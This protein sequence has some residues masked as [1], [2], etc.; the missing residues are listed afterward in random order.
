MRRGI[1]VGIAVIVAAA[2]SVYGLTGAH[3]TASADTSSATT[4]TPQPVESVMHGAL[5]NGWE[6][7]VDE[8]GQS[9]ASQLHEML[10]RDTALMD[11]EAFA[12][13][14]PPA[15]DPKGEK[16]IQSD[17]N[18]LV[19][20]FPNQVKKIRELPQLVTG[21]DPSSVLP[22]YVADERTGTSDDVTDVVALIYR[23]YQSS[24]YNL[25]PANTKPSPMQ[26]LSRAEC[27]NL[28]GQ[29]NRILFGGEGN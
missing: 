24:M 10:S 20:M 2:G 14:G 25:G 5:N 22:G 16:V 12:D 11:K 18:Q 23:A 21:M 15:P 8:M 6:K 9:R 27:A 7:I 17:Y 4:Q 19:Q 13:D 1:F 26:S 29:M 3:T 28:L